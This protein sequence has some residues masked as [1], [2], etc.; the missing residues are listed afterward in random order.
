MAAWA[1]KDGA[2]LLGD[3][4]AQPPASVARWV[5]EQLRDLSTSGKISDARQLPVT[6]LAVAFTSAPREQRQLLVR[7][8]VAGMTELPAEENA[9]FLRMVVQCMAE[10]NNEPDTRNLAQ[11]ASEKGG[12]PTLVVNLVKVANSAQLDNMPTDVWQGL[13]EVAQKEAAL[14]FRPRQLVDAVAALNPA[15]R[16]G[17]TNFLASAKLVTREQQ[18]LLDE[19]VKPGGHLD[20]LRAALVWA[21]LVWRGL[22]LLLLLPALQLVLA[23]ASLS[24]G[25]LLVAWLR[26]DALVGLTSAIAMIFAA[27]AV[28]PACSLVMEDTAGVLQRGFAEAGGLKAK[29][30]AALP[31]VSITSLATASA[32]A[33]LVLALLGFSFLWSVWG[34][35]LLPLAVLSGSAPAIAAV[36]CS[37]VL[38]VRM[39]I[40]VSLVRGLAYIWRQFVR[41]ERALDIPVGAY[42]GLQP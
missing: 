31:G 7:S 28:R 11:A 6:R 32:A 36:V 24:R 8:A 37:M 33:G 10:A 3:L 30:K 35:V 29:L 22:P 16:S 25:S 4:L 18:V 39:G 9:E 17:M 40:T 1:R 21:P 19:S 34:L 14:S 13:S 42:S 23:Y 2:A 20:Q 41:R 38:C 5:L 27:Q 26:L 12:P 15:E